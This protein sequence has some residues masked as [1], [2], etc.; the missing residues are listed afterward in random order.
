M[1]YAY[2]FEVLSVISGEVCGNNAQTR[3]VHPFMSMQRSGNGV[4]PLTGLS[5]RS[6][7]P[8]LNRLFSVR[9]HPWSLVM[10]D[11]D[12][13][14]LVNDIYGHLAG[15]DLLSHVGQTIQVNLK[16]N[17]YALRFGG[18]EFVVILP[19]TTGENALDLAQRLLFKLKKREFPGGLKISVSMGIAQSKPDDTEVTHLI[20][21]AD[22]ALYH[23]KET[24]R[25]RFVLADDL[26]FMKDVEPDFSHT[27]GRRDELQLL[28]KMVDSAI[29]DSA[30]FCLL[31]GFAGTGKT[32][33][34]GELFNYCQFKNMHVVSTESHPVYQEDTFLVVN[35]IRRALKNLT[36]DQL[37]ELKNNVISVERSTLEQLPEF[38][39]VQRVR[40]IPATPDDEK[41]RCREDMGVILREISR[42]IPFAVVLDNLQ[43]AST[44]SLQF[45]S[46][47][48]SSVPEARILYIAVSRKQNTFRYLKP[49]WTS[50]PL[51]R[52]HLK[53]LSLP[54]V[55]TMV[56]FAMK[57]PAIPDKVLK[58]MMR[59]SGGNALFLRKLINWGVRVGYLSIGRGE[60]CLWQEP[61]EDEL[62]DDIISITEIMLDLYSDEEIT[63]LKRA[64]LAG[65]N[66][67]LELLSKLT[68][69]SEFRLAEIMDRFVE[70]GLI[71]DT[72]T[73]FFF[74]YGVMR[75][76][77]ISRISPSLKQI[78][79]EK[80]A[81]F[82]AEK[83]T[84]GTEIPVTEIAHHF[85]KSLNNAKAIKYTEK[86]AIDTFSRGMHSDSIHWYIEYL[87]RVSVGIENHE[88]F[89]RAHINIGILYS[90]TGKS[91]LAEEHLVKA[92][93]LTDNPVDMC[94]IY[95]RLGRNFSRRSRYPSALY[96]F[97]MAVTVGNSVPAPSGLVINNMVGALLE[98]SFINLLQNKQEETE[99]NLKLVKSLISEPIEGID[100]AL[101]G[102]YY[103]R[104]A[105]I[106]NSAGSPVTALELYRKG[107]EICVRERDKTG[108]A[109]ILNNMHELHS[110]SGDYSSMLDTLKQAIKL[111]SQLGDQLGLAIGYYN[112]AETYTELNM[113]DLAKRYLQMYIELNSRI[114]N[115]LG[116][117]YGQFGMGRLSM[118]KSKGSRAA[119][120]FQNAA[121]IFGE[122]N[123]VEMEC[124]SKLDMAKALLAMGD[125]CTCSSILVEIEAS[126]SRLLF[127]NWLLHLK[128]V[129]LFSVEKD[130]KAI[131]RA[132][133]MIEQS[134]ADADKV[135][136]DE[137][138]YMHWNLFK[139]LEKG[140]NQDGANS[141]LVETLKLLES[142]LSN[143]EAEPIRNSILSRSDLQSFFEVCRTRGI[144]SP[145]LNS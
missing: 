136:P 105:D 17:D 143:I 9:K 108:E 130:K 2:I 117:A 75:S 103:A 104:L 137:M 88:A 51:K 27:V 83:R 54:D 59:Q 89:L 16:N 86:A 127:Q 55:R 123:F 111:N 85:C 28:R 3:R 76:Q 35:T 101:E 29:D 7:L 4:D 65:N 13:F 99:S 31:T 34:I 82:L 48:V 96:Y 64:A 84:N 26:E 70:N 50:V 15:D 44:R 142:R 79:H 47:V 128:G 126:D 97:N 40:T 53:P 63:I 91:E 21:R 93:S 39:F 45:V 73:Q 90:I 74:S 112:L 42:I 33:L 129:L 14:K 1:I 57:T 69:T 25:S 135:N 81:L 22:Q 38:N 19:D 92:I 12:H 37:L 114:D 61:E 141:V 119:E 133:A 145:L 106:E 100:M 24:G 94:V 41:A 122:L 66:L 134:I 139:A 46:E 18:D 107:L 98:T 5:N 23:A 109:L 32:K 58:Y 68:F 71:N 125:Y 62:P 11:I 116:I 36:A 72:G 60:I 56:F 131:S 10:L 115:R 6:I 30:R 77:L 144:A 78:L 120:Y 132:T 110:H 102:M 95:H 121:Q 67:D 118:V 124:G 20:S 80:T 113:L 140:N 43:W 52:I 8:K 87:N 138:V 49:V